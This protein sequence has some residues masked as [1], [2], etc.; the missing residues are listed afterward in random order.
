MPRRQTCTPFLQL[1]EFERGRIMGPQEA[2][3]SF[4][5]ISGHI[6]R[7]VSIM[8]QC[9]QQWSTDGTHIHHPGSGQ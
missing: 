7:E 5:K 8:H 2:G 4:Q 6:V 1:Y 3:W 9:W